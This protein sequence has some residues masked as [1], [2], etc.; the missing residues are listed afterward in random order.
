MLILNII[1][2]IICVCQLWYTYNHNKM[3][4]SI[5]WAFLTGMMILILIDNLID[6]FK[7]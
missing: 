4:N 2:L 3:L 5:Q 6:F 7:C 1:I